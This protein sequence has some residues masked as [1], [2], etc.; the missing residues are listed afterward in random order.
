[1][2]NRQVGLLIVGI[3]VLLFFIV[4][5]F[6]SALETI[7]NTT[8]DHGTSCPMQVTLKTQEKISYGLM[9]LLLL[10]GSFMAFFMKEGDVRNTRLSHV[11]KKKL[12]SGLNEEEKK[13]VDLIQLKEGS[14]YQ[15]DLIKESGMNKVKVSRILDRLEGKGLIDRKRRGMTNIVIL[16]SVFL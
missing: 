3:A 4:L 1:M 10:F 5:S 8:C 7:V 2:K 9:G 6:N 13:I 16:D 12:I 11:K 15:S 14:I